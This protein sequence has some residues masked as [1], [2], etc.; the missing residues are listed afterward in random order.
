METQ[1]QQQ[2]PVSQKRMVEILSWL[3]WAT[4]EEAKN[5]PQPVK[6]ERESKDRA[7]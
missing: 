6:R 1:P 7:A 4:E 2:G 3:F 5:K